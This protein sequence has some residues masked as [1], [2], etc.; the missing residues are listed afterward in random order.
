MSDSFDTLV[1][2]GEQIEALLEERDRLREALKDDDEW[3]ESLQ[4]EFARAEHYRIEN[5]RLREAL[6]KATDKL[7][8][9]MVLVGSDPEFAAIGVSEFRAT[10]AKEG[11]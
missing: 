6:K 10:L 3:R 4:K 9:A 2:L 5:D 11:Q 1:T 7:E 8:R